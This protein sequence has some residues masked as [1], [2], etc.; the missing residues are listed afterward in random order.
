MQPPSHFLNQHIP[1][2]LI[3]ACAISLLAHG[4]L[5]GGYLWL[6]HL[7]TFKRRPPIQAINTT[8]VKLGQERPK[9]LLPRIEKPQPETEP[10]HTAI[11]TEPSKTIPTVP[12]PQK[13]PIPSAQ[14]R[15]KNINQ[16]SKALERVQKNSQAYGS[17]DGSADGTTSD[18]SLAMLGHKYGAEVHR[19]IQKHYA[20]M[21]LNPTQVQGK[22]ATVLIKIRRDGSL[23]TSQLLESSGL[24]AFDSAVQRAVRLCGKVSPPPEEL[25]ETVLQD[26]LEI[27]FQPS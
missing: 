21:G 26:G 8:L 25:R 9:D 18:A 23:G 20:L 19:C 10:E 24:P 1:R 4:V 12:V 2:G 17:P 3:S 6:Q 22:T 11:K 27:V 5:L 14:D 13:T 16:V 7:H 15:I